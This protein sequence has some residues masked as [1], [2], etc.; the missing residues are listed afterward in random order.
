M[1]ASCCSGVIGAG[2]VGGRLVG[3]GLY[4]GFAIGSGGSLM[5]EHG[6]VVMERACEDGRGKE[7]DEMQEGRL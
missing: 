3:S 6:S 7:M 2:R 5:I 1:S 4:D